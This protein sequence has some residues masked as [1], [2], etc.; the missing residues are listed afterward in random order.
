MTATKRKRPAAGLARNPEIFE[1]QRRQGAEKIFY[2]SIF[3]KRH[4]SEKET[5]SIEPGERTCGLIHPIPLISFL[6]RV[7][8]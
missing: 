6:I 7:P 3:T 5:N 2:P 8:S 1:P 4:R